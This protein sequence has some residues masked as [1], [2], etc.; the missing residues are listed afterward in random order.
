M[1]QD[2]GT[3][4]PKVSAVRKEQL[5]LDLDDFDAYGM[6]LGESDAT[7]EDDNYYQGVSLNR[8]KPVKQVD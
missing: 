3:N 1:D 4:R 7:S 2:Y 8:Q 5:Q 6:E